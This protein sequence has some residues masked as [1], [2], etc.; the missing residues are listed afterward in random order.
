M[1]RS[2]EP[3]PRSVVAMESRRPSAVG[4]T[5]RNRRAYEQVSVAVEQLITEG[6][7]RPGDKLPPENDLARQFGVSRPTIREAVVALETAGLVEVRWG[8]AT[9]IRERR[10]GDL[11]LR[12]AALDSL[13]TGLLE[14]LE[15][16]ALIESELAA[17]AAARGAGAEAIAEALERP[18]TADP[19]FPSPATRAFHAGVAEA[20]GNRLLASI[21]DALWTMRSSRA[22]HGR[23]RRLGLLD[24]DPALAEERRRLLAAINASSPRDAGSAMQRIHERMRLLLFDESTTS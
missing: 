6:R 3:G 20:S 18:A 11:R 9:Y 22:W 10:L 14:Q 24:I 17:L 4:E 23:W 2:D 12:W 5:L 8:D 21:A 16:S 19:G 1:A 15:A 7:L 13:S